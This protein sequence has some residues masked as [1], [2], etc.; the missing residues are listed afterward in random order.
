MSDERFGFRCNEK[1]KN[2]LIQVSKESNLTPNK[3]IKELMKQS[4]YSSWGV[5]KNVIQ[6]QTI[7]LMEEI[8]K[9]KDDYLEVDTTGLERVGVKLCQLSQ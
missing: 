6:Q 9:I 2:D 4:L 7:N 5:P 1:L 8:Q 3:Y